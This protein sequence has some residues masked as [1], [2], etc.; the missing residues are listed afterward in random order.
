MED[1]KLGKKKKRVVVFLASVLIIIII[2]VPLIIA[3][4]AVNMLVNPNRVISH[5][6]EKAYALLFEELPPAKAWVE[7]LL[8]RGALRDTFIVAQD[9]RRL[10]AV[11]AAANKPTDKTAFVIHGWTDSAILMMHYGYMFQHDLGYNMFLP[12]LNGHG[13]SEGKYAQMGWFDRLDVIEWLDVANNIFAPRD[14]LGNKIGDTQMVIHG[15]SMGAATAMCVSGEPQKPYVKAYI[16]DCGYTSVMDEMSGDQHDEP[17]MQWVLPLASWW[18]GVI[19]GWTF[20]EASPLEMVKKSHLPMFFIHGNND[21]FVPTWMVHPLYEA[22]P[23]PKE[24]WLVPGARHA[25]SY[26]DYPEEYTQ[27]VQNFLEKYIR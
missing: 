17:L 26:F 9:G 5:N 19:H 13:L 23:E 14:S 10:H 27:R 3:N 2:V 4:M 21:N 20:Q 8:K 6:P 7:D 16:E 12:D 25:R 24:I 1:R 15:T 18:C 22:K 11:F